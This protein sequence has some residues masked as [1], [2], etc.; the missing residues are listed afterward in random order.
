MTDYYEGSVVR[1]TA[2]FTFTVDNTVYFQ[3]DE[4]TP[5][6]YGDVHLSPADLEIVR[7]SVDTKKCWVDIDTMNMSGIH[8]YHFYSRGTYKAAIKG[9]FKV[10]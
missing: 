9:Q 2:T 10:V 4:G 6:A 5:I 7:D 3:L 8:T 1:I